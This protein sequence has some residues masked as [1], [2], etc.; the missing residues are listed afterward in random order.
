MFG[1]NDKKK[2][3][4]EAAIKAAA[5]RREELEA[6]IKGGTHGLVLPKKAGFEEYP[7]EYKEFLKEVKA[8]P[9][10]P[11]ERAAALAEKILP[12]K[13]PEGFSGIDSA[14]K[15]GYLAATANGVTALTILTFVFFS[16]VTVLAAMFAPSG[17]LTMF[18][19]IVLGLA[20]YL[21][22]KY[23]KSNALA[24]T[25]RMS[26][27]SVLA[28]LYMVVY[29]RA[30]PNLEAALRFAAET[31]TGPLSWDLKKILWDIHV[32]VHPN[33]DSALAAY[34]NRWKTENEEFAEAINLIRSSAAVEASRRG[35]LFDETVNLILTGTAERTKLYVSNLR[36]PVMLIHAMGVLLPVMGL[37]LFPIVIIFMSDVVSPNVL[38]L[39]YDVILPIFLWLVISNVLKARPP[40]FSQPDVSLA[41][42]V[43]P[44]GKMLIGKAMIPIWPIAAAVFLPITLLAANA[45][46]T[47]FSP[48]KELSAMCA[49]RAMENVN[50]SIVI[51]AGLSLGIAAYMLL[52]SWQKMKVR[53]DIESI[54]RE[55]GVALFQLGSAITGGT[56]IELAMD[57][58]AANLKGM[59]IADLFLRVSYNMKR[60]GY[61][62]EQALFD[63]SV[64]AVWWYPS[65]L[66]RSV[67]T[68]IAEASKKGVYSASDAMLTIA[69]YLKGMQA[70]K[71]E[72]EEVLGE[73]IASMKFLSMLLTPLV[74]GVTIT[75]AVVILD[76]LTS[77]GTQLS[78][79]AASGAGAGTTANL[80]TLP[81]LNS[82]GMAITPV[83]FQLV[84]GLYMLEIAVLL[85]YFLN[86]IQF[87][88]DAI[89]LRSVIGTTVIAAL[90]VYVL[91]WLITYGMFGGSVKSM[92]VPIQLQQPGGE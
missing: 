60:F 29:M 3:L 67:M 14:A 16:L 59:K 6:I 10:S 70:V 13:T 7:T 46:G 24:V 86:R 49:A 53:N 11:Y 34:A 71:A 68:T 61:T 91:S 32:G 76:I 35:K 44:L 74:A 51:I 88:E 21:V 17:A 54:E 2:K 38:F 50:I 79:L 82:G 55:F 47:C 39:G 45:V 30:S 40:T 19:L 87:G 62:F 48:P 20:T 22:W 33:A 5:A 31:L 56:P 83:A 78:T 57:K 81:W 12:I 75:M 23:P 28:I 27:D 9:M 73:T 65:R 69:T 77:L 58:A 63:P 4:E 72:V 66:I 26:S 1:G 80:I 36:M 52:D 41:K 92:L 64:G 37:V 84:V 89:G 85:S 43:P 25:M 90:I 8:K 15:T 18:L 42:G